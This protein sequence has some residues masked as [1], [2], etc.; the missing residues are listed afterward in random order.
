MKTKDCELNDSKHSP[1]LICFKL[2]EC[3]FNL[4]NIKQHVSCIQYQACNVS[5]IQTFKKFKW[6]TLAAEKLSVSRPELRE[7]QNVLNMQFM[8]HKVCS[9]CHNSQNY[10]GAP[11]DHCCILT[12]YCTG[13]KQIKLT[14]FL[15]SGKTIFKT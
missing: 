12:T 5:R 8:H 9:N 11:V 3:N 2:C 14:D 7:I 15:Q 13:G 6:N 10:M 4:L 1:N